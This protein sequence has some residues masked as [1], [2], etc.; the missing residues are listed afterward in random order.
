MLG[1]LTLDIGQLNARD[2][3]EV[4]QCTWTDIDGC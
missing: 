3:K 4:G 2:W 1:G